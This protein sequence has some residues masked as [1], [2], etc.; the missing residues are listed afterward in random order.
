MLVGVDEYW[1][2]ASVPMREL[3]RLRFAGGD[4]AKTGSAVRIAHPAAWGPGVHREGRVTRL[5]GALDRETRLA[6]VLVTVADPLGEET[7]APSLLLGSI[8]ELA[9][10]GEPLEDVVRIDRDHLRRGDTVWVMHEGALEI[11][12]VEV[13]YRD[14]EHAFIAAGLEA[15]ETIVVTDLAT[16]TDGLPLRRTEADDVFAG[17]RRGEGAS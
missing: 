1:I 16:V 13:V 17:R 11:R 15:G 6:R 2:T 9:I 8:V 14:A 10:E 3:R 7:G 5:V 12:P 4:D